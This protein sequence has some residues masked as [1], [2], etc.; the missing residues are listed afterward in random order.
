MTNNNINSHKGFKYGISAIGLILI[1]TTL[2]LLIDTLKSDLA[3]ILNGLLTLV[4]GF[5]SILGI[6]I[7]LKGIK[8]PNTVKK[9]VGITINLIIVI[10]FL[11]LIFSIIYNN[12]GVLI[13]LNK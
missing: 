8:E 9:V 11:S 6:I 5:I 3:S 7:S 2:S 13:D 1:A 12:F 10:L 4:I